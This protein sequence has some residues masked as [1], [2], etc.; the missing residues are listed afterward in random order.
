MNKM[1]KIDKLEG[2]MVIQANTIEQLIIKCGDDEQ[3]SKR[4]CLRIHGIERS[5]D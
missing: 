1:K 5:D 2:E 3:Y 4:R